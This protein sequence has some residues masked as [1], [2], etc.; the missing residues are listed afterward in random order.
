LAAA[1]A[2]IVH[3][4]KAVMAAMEV[5]LV[6]PPQ[7]PATQDLV[8]AAAAVAVVRLIPRM[9]VLVDRAPEV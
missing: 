8:M 6:E 7:I 9:A 3:T 5:I 1:V 2:V 4:V